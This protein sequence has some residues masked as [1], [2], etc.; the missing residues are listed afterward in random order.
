MLSLLSG[1]ASLHVI[2]GLA[3]YALLPAISGGYSLPPAG[4]AI[5]LLAIAHVAGVLAVFAPS[6]LG[7]REAVLAVGLSA[8]MPFEQGLVVAA[9]L[10]GATLVA[11]A[12]LLT[13]WG[14]AYGLWVMRARRSSSS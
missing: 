3:F 13:G 8:S 4:Q 7:V 10:R 6:G 5:G 9:L 14:A 11:D 1:Y 12:I 2:V